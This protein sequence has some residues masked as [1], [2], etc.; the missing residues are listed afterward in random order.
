M[1]KAQARRHYQKGAVSLFVVIFAMLI[2]SVITISFLRLMMTDQ[3]QSANNDLAQSAYDSAQA[4]VEDAKRALL[5]YQQVCSN[6]G[7]AACALLSSQLANTTCNAGVSIGG[8]AVPDTSAG[9]EVK[10]QQVRSADVDADLDQA[11]TCLIME[12]ETLEYIG[13]LA[14][15]ESQVV[16]L[17]GT[18]NF[19][20]VKISWF[21][22]E[23]VSNADG[24]VSLP[25]VAAAKPL[26]EQE[27]WA[28]NRPSLMRAQLIQ[29]GSSFSMTDFD[30]TA[31]SGAGVQSNSNTVFLYPTSA[32]GGT[33]SSFV[34]LDTRKDSAADEPDAD[35]SLQTP[36]AL[37]C[38]PN[39]DGEEEYSC[40][41]ELTLPQPIGGG[42]R[43]AFLRLTPFYTKTHFE[44]ALYDGDAT[45]P[46]NVVRFKDV[47]PRIDSTGRANDL[48][49]RIES[50]VNL[51]NTDFP[52][53]D[54]TLDITGNL[55]KNFSVSSDPAV[56]T[57]SYDSSGCRP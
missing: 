53:P 9:G 37:Q 19:D 3:Q 38:E 8:I 18:R 17:V 11:Y 41:M 52:Y 22:R 35:T 4:G 12:L 27:D 57:D 43:T 24:R 20:T 55:C 21:S 50:R 5:R 15:G 16:P 14:P 49:R 13:T 44:V 1:N 7:P 32:V 45:I 10:V 30:Y 2:I 36:H 40:S 47:Q 33:S 28:V 25:G 29:F 26:I 42:N 48:F 46:A 31:G 23:D 51:Y 34:G 54:A 6:D 56:Y 39:F